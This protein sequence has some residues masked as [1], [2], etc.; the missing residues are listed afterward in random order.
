MSKLTL[1]ALKA[2]DL[3]GLHAEL[4]A[5]LPAL[6]GIALAPR[7]VEIRKV[8]DFTDAELTQVQAIL[9]SHNPATYVA[10]RNVKR[11]QMTEERLKDPKQLKLEDRVTRLEI[12]MGVA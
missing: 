10:A 3:G 12:L 9:A 8:G 11:Q 5:A 6:E 7:E 2:F 1:P 4:K